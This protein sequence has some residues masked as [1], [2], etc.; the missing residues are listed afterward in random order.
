MK[1]YLL[2]LLLASLTACN[3]FLGG[4]GEQIIFGMPESQW[5][6]LSKAEQQ[7]I[8]NQYTHSAHHRS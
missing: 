2:A 6:Q 1:N 3:G 5:T 8:M 7:R 4:S